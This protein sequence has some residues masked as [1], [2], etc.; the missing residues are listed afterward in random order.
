MKTPLEIVQLMLENDAFSNWMNLEVL[1]IE[2]G[3]CVLEMKVKPE[4]MNGFNITHGG[5]SYSLSD[6]ALAFAANSR[7]S[8]CV[9]LE[10]SISHLRP[11]KVNDILQAVAIEK[12]RGKTVGIY[13]VNIY[14]Q[15]K[16]IISIFKG[17]VH[18]SNEIW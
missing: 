3:S 8:K 18:I 13:E 2:E 10:T 4:M 14:N 11:T 16:K 17:T 12:Y 7:G 1:M 9:S 15:D 6:S 5:I